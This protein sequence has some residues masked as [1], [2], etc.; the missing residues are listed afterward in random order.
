M[1][2]K[3]YTETL[4]DLP[5]NWGRWGANDEIGSLNFLTD[6]EVLRGVKAVQQGK[7]FML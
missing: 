2:T 3:D 4:K 6:K 5:K 7:V 1:A